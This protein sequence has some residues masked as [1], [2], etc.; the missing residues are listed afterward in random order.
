MSWLSWLLGDGVTEER[1]AQGAVF[2]RSELLGA[3]AVPVHR[4]DVEGLTT[5]TPS[6]PTS[7][8]QGDIIG[9]RDVI[10]SGGVSII[11]GN[12][13]TITVL[14]GKSSD[15]GA[16]KRSTAFAELPYLFDRVPQYQALKDRLPKTSPPVCVVVVGHERDM[17]ELAPKTITARFARDKPLGADVAP[18]QPGS[19]TLEWPTDAK[20]VDDIWR[21]INRLAFHVHPLD[22]TPLST[23]RNRIGG[24]EQSVAISIMMPISAWSSNRETAEAWIQSILDS[25][26]AAG[27]FAIGFLV[28]FG[29]DMDDRNAIH[30]ELAN[31]FANE[32]RVI[33]APQLTM[34][35]RR[36]LR[37][38]IR[39]LDIFTQSEVDLVTWRTVPIK[40]FASETETKHLSDIWDDLD[41]QLKNS[42]SRGA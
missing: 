3:T 6:R 26:V 12:N 28:L 21:W 34:I 20:S 7:I 39:E 17:A 10:T 42:W 18:F 4:G 9:I 22:P 15:V 24:S 1:D 11:G 13:N 16:D 23:A 41:N 25:S 31:R 38:W 36:D 8:V 32:P 30:V 5:T 33:V 37:D 14:A 27:T 19:E 35:M 2:T 29:S 40:Y